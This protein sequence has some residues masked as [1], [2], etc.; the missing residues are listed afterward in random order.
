MRVRKSV[1]KWPGDLFT[2]LIWKEKTDD[3]EPASGPDQ[4]FLSCKMAVATSTDMTKIMAS[5]DPF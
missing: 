3:G 5:I 4:T 2:D 1:G